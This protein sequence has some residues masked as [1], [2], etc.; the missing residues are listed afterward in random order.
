MRTK[1]ILLALVSFAG[2]AFGQTYVAK[3]GY[4]LSKADEIKFFSITKEAEDEYIRELF[5]NI[6]NLA[7]V[8]PKINTNPE[9]KYDL[10][11]QTYVM[12]L[13]NEVTPKGRHWVAWI[14][15]ED[16][17]KSIILAA[18]S[19]D[20]GK[21]WSR[22]CLVIDAHIPNFP[23]GRKNIIGNFWKDPSGR[24]WL[25]FDQSM[26]HH[27]GRG[28]LWYTI[29]DNPDA[30][31]PSWSEP[32]RIWHGAMLNKPT[33]LSSGEWLLCSY[34]LQTWRNAP[35]MFPE[36]EEYR[37]VNLLASKDQGQTW[38][39]R[40][41]QK[42]PNPAWHEAMVVEK[43]NGQLWMKTRTRRGIMETFSDDK[44]YTWT[45]PVP[46]KVQHPNARFFFRKLASGRILLVKN[47]E[48]LYEHNVTRVGEGTTE[49]SNPTLF[50]RNQF[51]V[52]LTEDEGKTWKGGLLIDERDRVSYPDGTQTQDG[53]IYISY[54]H[55]RGEDGEILMAKITEED[56]LAGRIVN[57]NSQL[58]IPVIKPGKK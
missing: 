44:G 22:P 36:L 6:A 56:I 52:W 16:G 13:T 40:S 57:P 3:P 30:A 43:Q 38:E 9:P 20:D 45:E 48:N 18:R 46:S 42:F 8:P 5:R 7:L 55:N 12:S 33:V 49:L 47:G 23:V 25:F 21:T 17:P 10:D 35:A 53:T 2:S 51:S 27:D 50:G 28:G 54:E 1:I 11:Q 14:G 39:L 31:D 34:L 15:N 32:K 29:C 4:P 19:D 24:L 58:K 26:N 37:G 41:V